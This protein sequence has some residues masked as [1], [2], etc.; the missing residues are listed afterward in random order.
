MKLEC[1]TC[2]FQVDLPDD[3]S[4][5]GDA[6]TCSACGGVYD[7]PARPVR[8]SGE[9]GRPKAP[10]KGTPPPVIAG[11]VI[12][13]H[14]APPVQRPATGAKH[15]AQPPAAQE[16]DAAQPARQAASRIEAQP[17]PEN[18]QGSQPAQGAAAASQAAPGAA[19]IGET[20]VVH[21]PEFE[22]R[23][24]NHEELKTMIRSGNLLESEYIAQPG[25]AE[26]VLAGT[27]SGLKT[28]FDLKRKLAAEKAIDTEAVAFCHRHLDRKATCVCKACNRVYCST[29]AG[30]VPGATAL[31]PCPDCQG[32]L[33]ELIKSIKPFWSD[34][35]RL[36][37]YPFANM[38]IAQ[39]IGITLLYWVGE[40]IKFG[41]IFAIF[42]FIVKL[43]AWFYLLQ[44]IRASSDGK[45]ELPGWGEALDLESLIG[46]G[47][48]VTLVQLIV[49]APLI[50]FNI[51]WFTELMSLMG[52]EAPSTASMGGRIIVIMLGN[53]VL[54]LFAFIY[55]PMSL[56]IAAVFDVVL[57]V[58]NPVLIFRC[59][60]RIL[61]E[62]IVM[63]V[64]VIII[65]ILVGAISAGLS[66][67]PVGSSLIIA[68]VRIYFFMIEAHILGWMIY[69]TEEKLGWDVA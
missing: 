49:L 50:I 19:P 26:W 53:L 35:P 18:V 12:K 13:K 62:Y 34:I 41:L 32:E 55:F 27:V 46:R 23:L 44:I 43:L 64:F 1:P 51:F 63:L 15:G 6:I 25:D 31:V 33:D 30:R 68:F 45:T 36:F 29:C 38:G 28:Y 14:Q 65:E 39:I 5:Q 56:A 8:P 69:Q 10:K 66:V 9:S 20:W 4:S 54:L 16:T 37:V 17:S 2:G 21:R 67:I 22:G 59:I 57:P 7:V 47:F 3:P 48:K 11:Q 58:L 24:F 60:G 52:G 40:A 42:G 61:K